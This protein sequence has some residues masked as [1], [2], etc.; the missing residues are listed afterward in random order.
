MLAVWQWSTSLSCV[1]LV[2]DTVSALACFCDRLGSSR[3][4]FQLSKASSV[5]SGRVLTAARVMTRALVLP[6]AT[7]AR[8]SANVLPTARTGP[9]IPP[10]ANPALSH[11]ILRPTFRA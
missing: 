3:P 11:H 9:S 10:L 4:V 7:V 8:S 1:L 6:T 5:P 2:V